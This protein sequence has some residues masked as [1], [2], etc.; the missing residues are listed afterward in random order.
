MATPPPL[1]LSE[2]N[3]SG[4]WVNLNG[5][6]LDWR[7]ESHYRSLL[8]QLFIQK[9]NAIL[10]SLLQS[11]HSQLNVR[12]HINAQELGSRSPQQQLSLKSK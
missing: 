10:L 3:D 9:L 8:L 4:P 12:H 1:F 11:L 7:E 5:R 2:K 6:C